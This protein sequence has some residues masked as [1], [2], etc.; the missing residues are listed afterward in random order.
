M[1][2]SAD[3]INDNLAAT[4]ET[5]LLGPRGMDLGIGRP[6]LYEGGEK[7]FVSGHLYLLHVSRLPRRAPAQRGAVLVCIGDDPLIARYSE[8]CSIIILPEDVDFYVAFNTLQAIY[9]RFDAWEDELEETIETGGGISRMLEQSESVF[10]NPL[11][12]IDSDFQILG[13]SRMARSLSTQ[14]GFQS[15]DG[16][17]LR[18]GAFDQFL[19][20]H[21]LSMTE[22]E[23]LV[24]NLLDQTTLNFNLFEGDV[25]QGCLTVHYLNRT[26]R[27]SDKP[28]IAFLG[29]RLLRAMRELSSSESDSRRSLHQ[30]VAALLEERPLDAIER[31]IVTSAGNGRQFV[32]MRLKV[33][34]RFDQLPIGYV[35]NVVASTFPRSITLEYHR[36]SV[37]AFIDIGEFEVPYL[38]AIAAGISSFTSTMGMKAGLSDAFDDLLRCRSLFLQ[39]NVAL[40]LGTLFAP[41]ESVFCFQD[42]AL[43]EM[44]MNAVGDIPL[45]LRLPAGMRRLAEHDADAAISYVDTLRAYLE[46]NASVSK[47]ASALYVHRSTLMERLQRIRR[48]LDVDLDDPDVQLHLRL[49][50]KALQMQ[51]RL[52]G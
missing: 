37:V 9:D 30:A 5:R 48:E 33:P 16:R 41:A 47:A 18:L 26:Y 15:E 2:L 36:N 23:P 52:Q 7:P 8:R 28:L 40:D 27:Q 12:A 43:H 46:C 21:D 13:A 3:I 51:A 10:G 38:D 44:V 35:R 20:L 25:Y 29:G 32:C 24:L 39:A 50:L 11:Y 22:R 17:S 6:E 49:L 34:S 31:D 42:Y 4:W 45:D 1:K 19:E 14:A